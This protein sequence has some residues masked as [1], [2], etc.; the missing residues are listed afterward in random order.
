MATEAGYTG[1]MIR[2]DLSS[3]RVIDLSTR[4]Y[5][6]RFIGGR[7]IA[8]KIYWDEVSPD[9][10]A[11][12]P[13]NP[14]IFVTGPLAGFPGLSGSRWQV[15]GKSPSAEQFCYSNAGGSWGAWLKFA[16]YDGIVIQGKSDRPVCLFLHD[17]TAE[18]KDAS[19][20][21]GKGSIE[22]R[23]I[24]KEE[25]GSDVRVVA[26]GPAGENMVSFA[27]LLADEDSSLG[28]G[29]GAVAGSKKLKAIVVGGGRKPKA[30]DPAKLR[31]HARDVLKL[32]KTS[33]PR[34]CAHS[35]PPWAQNKQICYGC[36]TGCH[37]ALFEAQGRKGKFS[38]QSSV[39][40]L[41][42]ALSYYQGTETNPIGVGFL[43][44]KL[45]DEYGLDTMFV[46]PMVIWMQMCKQAGILTDENTG[47]PL[48]KFGSLEFIEVML[49]KIALR[50]GFGDALAQGIFRAADLV[51]S[52]ARELISD[53]ICNQA[54][55]LNLY[56]PRIYITTGLLYATEPRQPIQQ[57]HEAS[58]PV[59]YWLRWVDR[60]EDAFLS[61]EAIRALA[62]SLWGSELAAD[63]STYEGKAL[64]AKKIQDFTYAK[65]SL[66]LCDFLWPMI[67]AN[68]SDDGIGALESKIL[69]AVT[70]K[71]V[72]KEELYGIGERIFNLQRAIIIRERHEGRESDKLPDFYYTMP[73]P[74]ITA[75]MRFN[76]ECLVPG[77][78]GFVISKK[79]EVVNRERFEKMKD[80]YYQLR[81]WDAASGLQ[82][83]AKLEELEL[84]DIVDDLVRRELVV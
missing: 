15:C 67:Y 3:G 12:A 74:A 81:G 21:W 80:E 78:S 32:F 24:L 22:T 55:H 64:A 11:F 59:L 56:D 34:Q 14:L 35:A 72:D 4:D 47:M 19:A 76:P 77:N 17:G 26:I 16:G 84:Q 13:E 18:I 7:G 62:K 31:E 33:R 20:L 43:A 25:L 23:D 9:I 60:W 41:L 29:F 70:G 45:C 53:Y 38:C 75:G 68:Y 36:A 79:G 27:T 69:A 1:K 63:F 52:G 61:S 58:W 57:L 50:D 6:D 28:S 2:V 54:G 46:Q 5:A 71:E 42:Q 82:T 83:R 48:S 10:N 37:R 49:R 66:G 65:E 39:T 44:N 51:G 30:A 73:L 8:A 40:Y